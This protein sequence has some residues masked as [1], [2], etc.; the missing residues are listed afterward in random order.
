MLYYYSNTHAL[1]WLTVP[2]REVCHVCNA[3][4]KTIF[5]RTLKWQ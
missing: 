2:E 1:L 4:E 3:E 5:R